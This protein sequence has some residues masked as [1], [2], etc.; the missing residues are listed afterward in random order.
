MDFRL[1]KHESF[2][3]GCQRVACEE[4]AAVLQDLHACKVCENPAEPVHDARK[5]LKKLQAL[6]RLLRPAIGEEAYLR[7]RGRFRR[8]AQRLATA[9]DAEV[10]VQTLENLQKF[11]TPETRPSVDSAHAL[12]VTILSHHRVPA[13]RTLDSI[14]ASLVEAAA[15][16]REWSF[17]ADGSEALSQ[18]L[19][20]I[21]RRA[22][23]A[24]AE[25]A[26]TPTTECLHKWR[27]CTKEFWSVLRLLRGIAAKPARRLAKRTQDLGE[28]LGTD[29]DFAV[30][31]D[32][33][34]RDAEKLTGDVALTLDCVVDAQR[35]FLQ[36]QAWAL[37]RRIYKKKPRKL[38]AA[39]LESWKAE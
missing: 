38:A 17:A 20:R 15:A 39:L 10:C 11:A 12:F 32:A 33:L 22:R 21:Y 18:G 31:K 26:E 3:H 29:H 34:Q 16:I 5:H 36:D 19:K 23:R 7:E 25:A 13:Q 30:L 27:Q 1:K 37:G 8:A 9:R 14:T 24:G 28:L 2:S 35:T 4:I 6:L